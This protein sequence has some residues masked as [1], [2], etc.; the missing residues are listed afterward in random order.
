MCPLFLFR[1]IFMSINRDIPADQALTTRLLHDNVLRARY[2][3]VEPNWLGHTDKAAMIDWDLLDGAPIEQLKSHR[4]TANNHITHLKT[5]HG[6]EVDRGMLVMFRRP[7]L[8][9]VKTRPEDL[10]TAISVPV[11]GEANGSSTFIEGETIEL[12]VNVYERD[13]EARRQCILAHGSTC[14]I[15][16]FNFSKRYGP[17]AEGYIHVHHLR[18]LSEVGSAYEVNPVEDLR[19]VCPNCHAVLHRRVPAYSTE[20][21]KAFLR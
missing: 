7:F 6:L 16:S 1:V 5:E 2:E 20:E 17:V 10:P 13:P 12:I 21:V 3:G 8:P 4:K 11:P 9:S 15:C 14:C 18:P 19:P